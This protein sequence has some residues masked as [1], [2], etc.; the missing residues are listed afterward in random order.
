[1]ASQ[2]LLPLVRKFIQRAFARSKPVGLPIFVILLQSSSE[3]LSHVYGHIIRELPLCNVVSAVE[4]NEVVAFL[5]KEKVGV[6]TNLSPARLA[7][8]A[9]HLKVWKEIIA[10][11]LPCAIVLEDDVAIRPRFNPFTQKLRRQLPSEFDFIHLYVSENRREWR[12]R[13]ASTNKLYVSYTPRWG[14][15]AYLVSRSGAIKLIA[16]FRTIR[17]NGDR[18]ISTMAQQ[19]HLSVF[20]ASKHCVDN[21]GQLR[22]TYRGERFRSTI[23]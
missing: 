1:M 17:E 3:R 2:Q 18:Q 19:G 16:G 5:E 8:S 14:R 10:R 22:R 4:K 21:L 15:S 12:R 11:E 6:P 20:C 13:A 9:S 23:W 7:C